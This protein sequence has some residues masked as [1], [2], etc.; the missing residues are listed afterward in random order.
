MR[1]VWRS[2]LVLLVVGAVSGGAASAAVGRSGHKPRRLAPFVVL[3]QWHRVSQRATGDVTVTGRYVYIGDSGSGTHATVI[4]EQ[5]GKRLGLTPPAGCQFDDE[6]DNFYPPLGGSW[7]VAGCPQSPGSPQG[8]AGESYELYS[9]PHATWTPFRPNGTQMCALDAECAATN[10]Q[11][12]GSSY[13]A[14]GQRW[15]ELEVT[16]GY[17]TYP[18]TAAFEQIDT[19]QVVPQP[20]GVGPGG[21]QVL[22]LS[23]PTLTQTLCAPLRVPSTGAIAIHGRFALESPR[24]VTGNLEQ[25]YLERCG[26]SV[27]MPIGGADSM[28]AA[29]ATAVLWTPVASGEIDGLLLPSL[30][31]LKLR[32]PRHAASL[33]T[34]RTSPF[35]IT[36]LALAGRTVYIVDLG[37]QV[38]SAR[39][40]LEKARSRAHKPV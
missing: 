9:I 16:C 3:P 35:C 32:L 22:D 26:S 17:H 37:Y 8:L 21:R 13:A 11:D 7:V 15:I 6:N 1:A 18:S 29:S 12:C 20:A 38:W 39:I 34:R 2:V 10:G 14:I 4:D 24:D 5:T 30:R 23:S 36:E 25:T 31:P 27:H 40:P 33:C 28:F 19:G